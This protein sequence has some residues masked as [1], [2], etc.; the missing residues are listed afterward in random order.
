MAA[1]PEAVL[2]TLNG[3]WLNQLLFFRHGFV[4]GRHIAAV[5]R[6]GGVKKWSFCSQP[7]VKLV[8]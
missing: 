6:G 4:L 7:V 8:G 3:Y 1:H 5:N 2:I